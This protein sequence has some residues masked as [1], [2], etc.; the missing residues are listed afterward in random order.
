VDKLPDVLAPGLKIVFCGTAAGDR[1]AQRGCYYAGAGNKFWPTLAGI[2]LTP[3]HLRPEEFWKIPYFGLG[4]TDLAKKASGL[5]ASL[6]SH[7]FDV[8][9]FRDRL[10][11]AAP[12]FVAF[13]GKKAAQLA[14]KQRDLPY[15][16]V[17]IRIG[18]SAVFVL[19]STSGL[20]SGR[21]SI[22]PWKALAL[23]A[24]YR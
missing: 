18:V 6:R 15:G 8:D 23:A 16:P 5:D 2:G 22:E 19:P 20:A 14:L 4:L 13:N 12:L 9:G 17:H 3:R 21:W 1:S 7:D 10:T 24:H 11:T